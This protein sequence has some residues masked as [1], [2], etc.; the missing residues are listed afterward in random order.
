MPAGGPARRRQTPEGAAPSVPAG[1]AMG[2]GSWHLPEQRAVPRLT[3]AGHSGLGRPPGPVFCVEPAG[4]NVP[5]EPPHTTPRPRS[6]LSQ[7]ALCSLGPLAGQPSQ[8]CRPHSRRRPV[9]QALPSVYPIT[10]ATVC[11]CSRL[12][13]GAEQEAAGTVPTL[14]RPRAPDCLS[15]RSPAAGE[16]TGLPQ[17]APCCASGPGLHPSP[18]SFPAMESRG[19]YIVDCAVTPS[20][21]DCATG[22]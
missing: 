18:R 19:F 10:Q 16:L 15:Q 22:Q 21:R 8:L 11:P 4:C 3:S 20:P 17:P 5:L 2:S 14:P 13:P 9:H 12:T 6:P 1:L 7:S